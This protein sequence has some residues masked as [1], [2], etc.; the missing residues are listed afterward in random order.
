MPQQQCFGKAAWIGSATF[1]QMMQAICH[2]APDVNVF[3]VR[4]VDHGI[5]RVFGS[6]IH[7]SFLADEALH[8]KFAIN[9]SDDDAAVPGRDGAVNNDGAAAMP[10]PS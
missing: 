9:G 5:I 3:P 10:P 8:R 4:D 1:S 7:S 2:H 6:K